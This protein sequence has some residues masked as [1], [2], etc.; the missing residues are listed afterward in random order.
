[1]PQTICG[2][3]RV[4]REHIVVLV[5]VGGKKFPGIA[6]HTYPRGNIYSEQAVRSG[7]S[8]RTVRHHKDFFF[9]FLIL[10]VPYQAVLLVVR[11]EKGPV[12]PPNKHER[13][14]SRLSPWR[15]ATKHTNPRFQHRKV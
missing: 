6:Y 9:I 7:T 1:M 4:S 10:L 8:T 14:I 5:L 3:L 2:F 13:L 12:R 11:S 15:Q